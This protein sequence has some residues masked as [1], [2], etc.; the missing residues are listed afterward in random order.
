MWQ[1]GAAKALLIDACQK[2]GLPSF[3]QLPA[4]LGIW[5]HPALLNQGFDLAFA[6]KTS[7]ALVFPQTCY[8]IV[9]LVNWHSL[10]STVT[11][12]SKE[13]SI[14]FYRC[15][16]EAQSVLRD[17]T[18]QRALYCFTSSLQ[19]VSLLILKARGDAKLQRQWAQEGAS[20]EEKKKR[21]W[22]WLGADC[23][24]CFAASK[25]LFRGSYC[26]SQ[27]WLSESHGKECMIIYRGKKIS[28]KVAGE[29]TPSEPIWSTPYPP[30]FVP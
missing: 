22:H 5:R 19:P 25:L 14:P 8:P 4:H 18:I 3:S 20:R 15:E 2:W 7:S 10:I 12:F 11:L 17:R 29:I 27:S 21:L 9:F 1:Q 16:C 6:G 26:R 24:P 30:Q 13:F 28:Q 23:L